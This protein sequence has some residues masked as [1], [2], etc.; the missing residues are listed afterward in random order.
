[1]PVTIVSP[2]GPAITQVS[3]PSL[4]AAGPTSSTNIGDLNAPAWKAPFT[5]AWGTVASGT[6][7]EVILGY[8]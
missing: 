6:E 7:Q 8:P 1:M 5:G 3:P 4:S 2:N